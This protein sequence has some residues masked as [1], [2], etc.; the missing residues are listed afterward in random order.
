LD[1]R[2]GQF[3]Q[4]ASTSTL[5]I[6]N[7]LPETFYTLCAYIVNTFGVTSNFTCL[8]LS[9]MTWGSVIKASLTFGHILT[10]Q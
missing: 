8:Q 1:N 4:S 3:F 5:R 9:T 7:L 6:S 10:S 2:L